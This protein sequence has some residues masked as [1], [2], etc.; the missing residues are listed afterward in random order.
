MSKYIVSAVFVGLLS[1]TVLTP[2]LSNAA[3]GE[4]DALSEASIVTYEADFFIQYDPVSLLDMLQR[5]PGISD[6]LNSGRRGQGRG[7]RGF[8]NSGD[9]I[10]IDG[11]DLLE[12]QIIL[13]I[14]FHAFHQRKLLKLI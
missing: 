11:K 9:Q 1:S 12:N 8:G 2:T 4:E 14:L 6:V 5:I 13:M 7:Q 3:D 10:L